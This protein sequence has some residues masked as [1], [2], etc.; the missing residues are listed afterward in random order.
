MSGSAAMLADAADACLDTLSAVIVWIGVRAKRELP[1]SILII[2]LIFATSL[3][4][5]YTSGEKVISIFFA[6][7]EF[8][9]LYPWLVISVELIALLFAS[10]L[11]YYQ[12]YIGLKNKSL[13]LIIQSVDSRNHIFVSM[14]V[15][16]GAICSFFNL[17]IVDAI[18]GLLLSIRM[19]IDGVGLI[20][21]LIYSRKDENPDYSH[22]ES[23]IFKKWNFNKEETFKTWMLFTIFKRKSVNRDALIDSLEITFK[24]PYVPIYSEYSLLLGKNVDFDAHIDE[25]LDDLIRKSFVQYEDGFFILAEEGLNRIEKLRR[26]RGIFYPG[27]D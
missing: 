23:F 13:S 6:D 18:I 27:N 7:A 2:I 15:I 17:L 19:F 16:L 10:L 11:F 5:A 26:M 14:A 25:W 8:E 4:I 1:G 22:Y 3:S 24:T 20:K 9:Y 12:R 21:E